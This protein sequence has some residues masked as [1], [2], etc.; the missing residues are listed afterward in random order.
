MGDRGGGAEQFARQKQYD[1]KANSN[2]VLTADRSGRGR[3]DGPT[4][5]PETLRGKKLAKM[6]DRLQSAKPELTDEQKAKMK[7]RRAADGEDAMA[8]QAKRRQADVALRS[9]LD[10][11]TA[12]LYRPQTA[13]TRAAYEALLAKIQAAIGDQPQ[14][15]LW[16]AADEVLAVLKSEK[17]QPEKKAECEAL[18]GALPDELFSSYVAISSLINDF[19]P[20]S[21]RLADA[22]GA[23]ALGDDDEAGVAVEFD[24]ASDEE[25]PQGLVDQVLEEEDLDEDNAGKVDTFDVDGGGMKVRGGDDA[26]VEGDAAGDAELDLREVDAYWLQRQVSTALAGAGADEAQA[27]ADKALAALAGGSSERDLERQLVDLLDYDNFQ[28]IKL[29]MDHRLAIVCCTR[30]ARA[31]SDEERAK[32][33]ADMQSSAAGRAVLAA[34]QATR[35]TARERQERMTQRIKSEAARLRKRGAGGDEDGQ[36]RGEAAGRQQLNLQSLEFRGEGHFM[37]NKSCSLPEGS[38]RMTK[39]GYEEVHVPALKQKPLG[40]DERQVTIEDLPEWSRGAFAGMKAL[41]R[42]QSRVYNT[43]M[44]TSENILMCA[45]TGA[46]KTNVA[47]LAVMHEL[48]LHRRED[49]TFDLSEFKIVYVAPMK[50]LVA[51]MVGNFTKRLGEAYGVRVQELTGDMSMTKAEIEATQIIVTTPEKWDIITRKSGD[52]TYTDR[53][54][55]VIID[56]IHLLHDGRGPVL[57]NI[58]ARTVRQIEAT[59]EM[60]RLVGL[61]ATLPNYEDVAAFLRVK[62]DKGL[63]FFDNSYRPCPLEQQFIGVTVRKPL[64]RFQLQNEICYE[65]VLERAGKHQVLIFVHSRK[66]TS[67]TAKF[68][69]DQLLSKDQLGR[70]MKDDSATREILQA[71]AEDTKS[72]D[73]KDLL[74]YGFATHHAGMSRV[75]RTLVEDLFANGHVQVLVSTATLAWGVNL[76]AHTVIIKGTQV[77][78]PVKSAWDELSMLDMMQMLGR[79]G[80]PQFDSHG[81]GIIITGHSE[82]QYYLSLMN[83]QLPV[84]SQMVKQLANSLNA[85]VVLGTVSN[86]KEAANWLGYTYLYVRMLRNPSLYGVPID[87]SASDPML[88][89]WRMDLAH[90]A[91][92]Q[93][94]RH[95]LMRYDR[96]TGNFQVTDLGRIASHYYVTHDTISTYNE[97]LRPTMGEIDLLRL[98][99]LSDE[100]KYILVREE[101]KME[102]AKIIERVP[103]PVKESIEEPTAKINVLL[104]AYISRLKLDGLALAADMVYVTQSAGR[105]MR[106]IYEVCLRQNWA[107]LAEKALNLCKMVS[108]RMW[109]SQTPLRQFKDIPANIL[110]SLEKKEIPWERYYDLSSQEL[111]ELVRAPKVGKSLHRLVHQFPRVQLSAQVQPITRSVL[112]VDLSITPDFQ[113]EEKVHGFVEPFVIV[114]EDADS[115]LVLHHEPF[116]LKM[117]YAEE[118]HHVSFTVPIQEP[119]PPQYFVRVVSDRWLR[120]EA[121]LPISFRHLIL[122]E[123]FSPPTELLDLQPLPLSALRSADFEAL[124]AG[125]GTPNISRF[126]PIQTQCFPALFN[127]DDNCLVAAPTGSGK[128]VCAEFALLRMIQRALNGECAARCV[129]V[130]PKD[131]LCDE[132]YQDWSA[133]FGK[134]LGLTVLRLTGDPAADV[135]LL[136]RGNIVIASPQQWDVVSRR[137]RQRKAVQDVALFIVDELHL[138]G[139]EGGHV[140]EVCTSRMRFIRHELEKPIRIVGLSSSVA[141]ARDLGEWLGAP[142]Q[143]L[144]SFHP[145]VRP[146]PLE[147]HIKSF[148]TLHFDARMQAMSKPAYNAVATHAGSDK[149][150]LAFVPTRKHA[151]LLC[152]DLLTFA[153]ADGEPSKFLKCSEEDLEPFLAKIKDPALKH[154]LQYGIGYIHDTM[155]AAER[156]AVLSLFDAGA[157]QVLAATAATCW[158]VAPAAHLVII[159]GTQFFDGSGLGGADYPV[160]DLL[161]MIGRASRPGKDAVGKLMLMC[162]STKKEYY[163]R[164][165][166]EPVPVESHVDHSLHDHFNAEIVT[167]T[168][169]NMQGALDWLTWT[170]FYRR[171][172]Q[173]PNYYNLAGNTPRHVS[174][175]LSELVEAT[176]SDLEQANAIAVEYETVDGAEQDLLTPLNLGKIAAFHC[177]RYTT[178]ELFGSSLQAKT[179]LRGLLEIL[180]AAT[181]FATLPIRPG[182]EDAVRKLVAHSPI[183]IASQKFTDPHV[184]ANALLQAHFSRT[185]LAGDLAADQ[186]AVVRGASRLL[187]AVVDVIASNGWLSPALA[188]ME[189][190][191]MVVQGMWERDPVLLQLP[192]VTRDLAA[193]AKAIGVESVFELLD[194]EDA[195]RTKLLSMDAGQL[196]E[197]ARVCNRYPDIQ[198]AHD[199][200]DK[201]ELEAGGM[202][203]VMVELEREW[204]GELP[205]VD[206]QK[207]P[208]TKDESWWLVVGNPATNELLKIRRVSPVQQLR[209]KLDFA[210]PATPG[211]HKLVLYFMCDSYLGCDQEYEF[212]VELKEG[213]GG[214]DSDGDADM[215]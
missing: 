141:N 93:L 28:L 43:A 20:E 83:Q 139:G 67:K 128:T 85:E 4:G 71:E 69:R 170:F 187:G 99:A 19:T 162:A 86:L 39:K 58:V 155:P 200:A 47:M 188:A 209:V 177:A 82:L 112:K 131:A 90:S 190:S 97:H 3:A 166:F 40:A 65:K 159:A 26:V 6:G 180:C 37:S 150:V 201:D 22:A 123:K 32:I 140:L 169:E 189:L 64:Q 154:G 60:T 205:P 125:P 96:R 51:E 145:G 202:V 1:Y 138:L 48:G 129:Y 126:N 108:R 14:D 204:E 215:D 23:A 121:Q 133:R 143:A 77:Y 103:I 185:P 160:A 100:F 73:L 72:A 198:L 88:R 45:P 208:G 195:D 106:C 118:D 15:V 115:E 81:E 186:R 92:V 113:W 116:M 168:I 29:L 164:F 10:M 36:A 66:E 196:A 76:P 146:V 151:R 173:N 183:T 74:P 132:R 63:F 137:W 8:R 124:Y 68:L 207:Y 95:Q 152:L 17:R 5:M 31:Q 52:R 197:L 147:F 144:F 44:F 104:Q 57:E 184:K 24:E 194:M 34:L 174:D 206:S 117:Q 38:F 165:L 109:A 210:A 156:G 2:L 181:E 55:L 176:M 25:D 148:D 12:G 214:E 102:L 213:E 179:K 211:K 171:L 130:A 89:D 192:H 98:F 161:Q 13:E 41:N 49:G 27:V 80:R 53:V 7:K 135:K 178:I 199:V 134:G 119:V 84:E 42:I 157:I 153:A 21:E 158:G 33:E 122:P 212:E 101:E 191:Q 91:A 56:E 167:R 142:Q 79:A 114:V 94:D 203:S 35:G 46:G 75:D 105:L 163:K 9:V 127:T 18:L 62:P 175:H 30:L 172:S 70:M 50:A 59:Q 11:D 78:N 16:G 54:R 110:Q 87:A 193:R 111:G 107:Q 149:P 182:E 61:S 120:C 136:D